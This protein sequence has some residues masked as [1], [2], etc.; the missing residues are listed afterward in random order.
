MF[1]R[2]VDIYHYGDKC[3]N[4]TLFKSDQHGLKPWIVR[5]DLSPISI[6]I[7][8]VTI[9]G[10]LYSFWKSKIQINRRFPYNTQP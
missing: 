3:G 5:I 9:L 7:E 2:T 1:K 8:S 4:M 10:A 6:T